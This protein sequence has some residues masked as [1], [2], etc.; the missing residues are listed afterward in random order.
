MSYKDGTYKLNLGID[1][2]TKS[3]LLEIGLSQNISKLAEVVRFCIEYTDTNLSKELDP[4]EVATQLT[5]LRM[6]LEKIADMQK[7]LKADLRSKK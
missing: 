4:K 3:I 7:E 2:K 5:L 6:D 1:Q